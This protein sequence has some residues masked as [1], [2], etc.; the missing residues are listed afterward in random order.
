[1]FF[2]K[3]LTGMT[4]NC[5]DEHESLAT[6][7]WMVFESGMKWK[8]ELMN[9]L[10]HSPVQLYAPGAPY[11]TEGPLEVTAVSMPAWQKDNH[12]R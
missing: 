3:L 8:E 12:L 4:K 5:N 10:C 1:M 2:F 7:S 9:N 6:L 11:K